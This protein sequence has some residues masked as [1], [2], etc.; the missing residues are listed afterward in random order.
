MLIKNLFNSSLQSQVSLAGL[1]LSVGIATISATP[2]LASSVKPVS[3]SPTVATATISGAD[4]PAATQKQLRDGTYL[5]GQTSKPNQVGQEY[6]VF[7]A[8][9]GKVRGAVYMPSSEFSCFYGTAK[10]NQ[11]DLVVVDPYDQSTSSYAI[12]LER[13]SLVAGQNSVGLQGY[14][15]ISRITANDKRILN[16]C[17]NK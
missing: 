11:M 2:T 3:S 8:R 13:N 14:Q 4:R 16:A 6:V 15:P 17:G 1:L 12:G 7:E 5:F 9:G 10:N